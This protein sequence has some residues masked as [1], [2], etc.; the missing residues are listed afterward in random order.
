M[1]SF[2]RLVI[3]ASVG[4]IFFI[5]A[6]LILANGHL[7]EDAY[8]LFQYSKKLAIGSAISFDDTSGP[9]EG[10]TDFL[11]MA[12]LAIM[13]RLGLD[14]GTAAALLNSVGLG[15]TAYVILKLNN[16]VDWLSISCILLI[17][18]SGGFSAA[19]GGFS[20]LAYGGLFALFVYTLLQRNF[21][22]IIT[23]A[24]VIPLFRP[25]GLLLVL[26]GI[27]TSFF[28]ASRDEKKKL[29]LYLLFPLLLGLGYFVWRLQYF[30]TILPLPL[31]VKVRTD[32]LL[33]GLGSNFAALRWY[34]LL[35]IPAVVLLFQKGFKGFVWRDYLLAGLGPLLLLTALTFAHQSQNVGYRF[36]YPIM[37]S[38][39]FIYI[40]SLN[41]SS[42]TNKIVM[43]APVIG[44]LFGA[45]IIRYDVPYLT[46]NDY[47]NSF[48]QMLRKANF[49]GEKIAITEAGRF[50]FWYD[51]KE[52]IDLVGLN[53][54]Q[55]LLLGSLS[56]LNSTRP[57]LIFIH[58]AGRFDMS[59]FDSTKPYFITNASSIKI[60]SE[61]T[62]RN[63][64][65]IAPEAA[66]KFATE[67]GYVAIPVQYGRLDR[68]F[69][70]VYFLSPQSDIELF[71]TT[72][73]QS[74]TNKL[75]YYESIES[76]K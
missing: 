27:A 62:G 64:V 71:M 51:T 58:Q 41:E 5:S 65:Y 1:R 30:G 59:Q 74:W 35:L 75:T 20:T 17:I 6:L 49:S 45:K 37:L 66:L 76:Q 48:P 53:S 38:F 22:A 42:I 54:R 15:L 19:L 13:H 57:S 55:V 50:P 11:W 63:P 44:V 28:L 73:K 18:F 61:Y 10:A 21:K 24:I 34:L 31:L 14:L 70:H 36:Q 23:L 4:G 69:M 47:I 9:T 2:D 32:K 33:E 40:I 43:F 67:S 72:L 8:I 29:L 3:S 60:K 46:N 16:K 26:G 39:I 25:D 12:I 52:M 56:V 68:N 7:H